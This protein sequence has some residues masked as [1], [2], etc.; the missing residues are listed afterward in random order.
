MQELT[1][2]DVEMS[3]PEREELFALMEEMFATI[4]HDCLGVEI[5]TPWPRMTYEEADHR[6]GSDKPDTRFGL[7]LEDATE[8]TRGSQ[9]G[10]FAGAD[11][12][13][14]LRVPR[15]YSRAELAALEEVAKE[16]GAKGL[17]Y[18]VRD[19]GG[20]VRS[21]IAK[22]LSEPELEGLAPAAGRRCSS[23]R[24]RGR[25]RHVS[26]ATCACTSVASWA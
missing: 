11:A 21:P 25:R 19:E 9:F 17:A 13:R 1:Q 6:F 14:F 5:G 24:T 4:W 26:S 16:R 12:V 8:L 3:F 2:L 7:E 10:V 23:P 15:T 20:E 18:V 22:F